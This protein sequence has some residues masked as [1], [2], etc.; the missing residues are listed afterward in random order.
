[1]NEFLTWEFLATFA[2]SVAF[3]TF[4]TELVKYYL[5]KIDPKYIALVAAVVVTFAVRL[6]F[7]KDFTL[8][9]LVLATFNVA[10]VLFAAIGT[11]ESVI[12]PIERKLTNK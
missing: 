10:A 12:K 6:L 1:M 2:G 8:D 7:Y 11:F 3:V 4:V 9:G 5:T